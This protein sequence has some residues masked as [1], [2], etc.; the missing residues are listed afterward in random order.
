MSDKAA[1][2]E[3]V[4]SGYMKGCARVDGTCPACGA[5]ALALGAGCH[6]TC[7]NPHCP[8]PVAVD[9]Y[10]NNGPAR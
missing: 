8:D 1:F 4:R 10:L 7:G 3:V 5:R 6:V 9:D 2:V